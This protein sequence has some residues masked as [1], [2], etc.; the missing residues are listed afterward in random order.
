MTELHPQQINRLEHLRQQQAALQNVPAYIVFGQDI[1]TLAAV[2]A[3]AAWVRASTDG[4]AVLGAAMGPIDVA[5][6]GAR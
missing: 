3:G 6:T 1:A 2:P 4:T 5:R